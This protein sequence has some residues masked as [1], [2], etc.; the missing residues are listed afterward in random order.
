MKRRTKRSFYNLFVFIHQVGINRYKMKNIYIECRV[1]FMGQSH[2]QSQNEEK[3]Y[4]ISQQGAYWHW[5][6]LLLTATRFWLWCW[7]SRGKHPVKN[8]KVLVQC[9]YILCVCPSGR[10]KTKHEY[11]TD[12][13]RQT[14]AK[15][16]K[17]KNKWNIKHRDLCIICVSLSIW[18]GSV[19]AGQG[20]QYR[21]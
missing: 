18:Q 3:K 15:Y 2:F 16:N 4:L 12:E 6:N 20:R 21:Q 14:H 19:W 11:L 17:K 7:K 10:D 8:K 13:N 1:F 5:E 9:T